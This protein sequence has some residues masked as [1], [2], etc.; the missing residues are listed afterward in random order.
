MLTINAKYTILSLPTV[1][2]KIIF[3]I[4]QRRKLDNYL[5]HSDKFCLLEVAHTQ[6]LYGRRSFLEIPINGSHGEQYEVNKQPILVG[7]ND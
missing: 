6:V 3:L 2:I 1:I 7:N 4:V 5:K